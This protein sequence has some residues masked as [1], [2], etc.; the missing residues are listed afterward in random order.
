M[1]VTHIFNGPFHGGAARGAYALHQSL[2]ELG[3]DSRVVSSCKL[4]EEPETVASSSWTGIDWIEQRVR[5]R[6]DST[7]LRLRYPNRQRTTFSLAIAGAPISRHPWVR[8]ADIV[9]LHWI[10]GGLVRLEDIARIEKPIVWT[11]RDMWPMTGGCHYAFDC[12]GFESL[13]GRCPQLNSLVD[14]DIS[15]SLMHGKRDVYARSDITYVGISEWVSQMARK[16]NAIPNDSRVLTIPNA[17]PTASFEPV[18]STAVRRKYGLPEDMPIVLLGATS[19]QSAYKGFDLARAALALLSFRVFVVLFGKDSEDVAGTLPEAKGFGT[20]RS[21]EMLSELYSAADVFVAPSVA[22]AFG[23]TIVESM[24]CRTPVVA[25]N[26]TGPGSIIDHKT[27]GYLAQAFD[28]LDL[29]A[30]IRWTLEDEHR[31][32]DVGRAAREKVLNE[33]DY[34]VVAPQYVDLYREILSERS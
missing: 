18:D 30:G 7:F 28:P 5:R 33:F 24:S 31:R 29:A 20:I 16:S 11:M 25:F 2:R 12:P 8:N 3:I 14:R 4:P 19:V 32:E 22:E 13:C 27:N 1:K 6:I 9:H 21:D 23:K 15:R 26:A 10:N 17:I 34:S